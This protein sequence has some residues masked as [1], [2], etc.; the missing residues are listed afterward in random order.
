MCRLPLRT[1]PR[2]QKNEA[3]ARIEYLASHDSLTSL[4]NRK[5]STDCFTTRS[6]PR[7]ATS[8]GLR[9]VHRSRRSRSS[10]L[11]GHEAGDMLLVE[12]ANRLR[13]TL[14]SSAW[15]RGWAATNSSSI[16]EE[17]A[18]SHDIERITRDLLSVLSEPLH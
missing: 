14:R 9:I 4:P 2:G 12:I 11:A 17:A 15:W 16:L 6:K 10:R 1:R 18:E 8:G 7:V 3:D 13:H 5:R